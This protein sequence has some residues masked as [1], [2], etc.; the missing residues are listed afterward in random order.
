MTTRLRLNGDKDIFSVPKN[1]TELILVNFEDIE[2]IPRYI[3]KLTLINCKNVTI[4]KRLNILKVM[5]SVIDK[6][7]SEIDKVVFDHVTFK[8][9]N[10]VSADIDIRNCSIVKLIINSVPYLTIKKCQIVD[11]KVEQL[12]DVVIQ[13][14]RDVYMTSFECDTLIVEKCE[15][16]IAK[17]ITGSIYLTGNGY[18]RTEK[19][20]MSG[21]EFI[22]NEEIEIVG[23]V[24]FSSTVNNKSINFFPLPIWVI[25]QSNVN[26]AGD[27]NIGDID[28][29]DIEGTGV[30]VLYIS[31]GFFDL[32]GNI[33]SP[34]ILI[35]SAQFSFV[36]NI[37]KKYLS[38]TEGTKG[39]I[40]GSIDHHRT[41]F[42][43]LSQIIYENINIVGNLNTDIELE[44]GPRLVL[45]GKLSGNVYS[46]GSLLRKYITGSS[47]S[48]GMNILNVQSSF[49]LCGNNSLEDIIIYPTY[50]VGNFSN[51][52]NIRLPGT[53]YTWVGNVNSPIIL[54]VPE[55]ESVGGSS[56]VGNLTGISIAMETDSPPHVGPLQ[57]TGKI[58]ES[59]SPS[60][61]IIRY[62]NSI[63]LNSTVEMDIIDINNN[64]TVLVKGYLNSDNINIT[65]N[66]TVI[67]G[68]SSTAPNESGN[69][70][71]MQT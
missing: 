45:T 7:D 54:L 3:R 17:Y 37:L 52:T 25:E 56:L 28:N 27:V 22:D 68:P 69:D 71:Y 13:D 42:I 30:N 18:V 49:V 63:R 36:G 29:Q 24:V 41:S 9:A 35:D 26:I 48:S 66:G 31:G 4:P 65:D 55:G 19:L 40:I 53:D 16:F 64:Q 38:T 33:T 57:L 23:D 6:V 5:Y 8:Q 62:I 2:K 61:L 14:C 47:G 11:I 1:V 51:T 20:N 39:K 67:I 59:A 44:E 58:T 70:S 50:T 10:L 43:L 21:A 15:N 34:G 46:S 12:E 32:V 60:A